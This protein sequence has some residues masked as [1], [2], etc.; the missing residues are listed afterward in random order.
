MTLTDYRILEAA[1]LCSGFSL[2]MPPVCI[3]ADLFF[4]NGFWYSCDATGTFLLG[5]MICCFFD[6]ADGFSGSMSFAFVLLII[7]GLT[8]MVLSLVFKNTLSVRLDLLTSNLFRWVES[9]RWCCCF[10]YNF[11]D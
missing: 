11:L 5:V 8:V 3:P 2:V 4:T 7:F 1:Y 10:P 6:M 9:F